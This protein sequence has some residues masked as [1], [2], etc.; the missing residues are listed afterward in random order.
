[1]L[2]RQKQRTHTSRCVLPRYAPSRPLVRAL[3][4]STVK[5]WQHG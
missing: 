4:F 5:A 2:R 3:A 1:M